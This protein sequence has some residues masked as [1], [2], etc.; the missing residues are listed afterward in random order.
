[1]YYVE[2]GHLIV[3]DSVTLLKFYKTLRNA[4]TERQ[5]MILH[6]YIFFCYTSRGPA[7]KHNIFKT[8]PV[9]EREMEVPVRFDL[10]KKPE[11]KKILENPQAKELIRLYRL[12][13]ESDADRRVIHFQALIKKWEKRQEECDQ[14]KELVDISNGLAKLREQLEDARREAAIDSDDFVEAVECED[15]MFEIP[16]PLKPP[17]LRLQLDGFT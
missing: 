7:A 16:E 15:F 4:L 8:L 1:M 3:S 9:A 13:Q 5:M 6:Q 2:D 12:T 17:H 10:F 11:D 14:P